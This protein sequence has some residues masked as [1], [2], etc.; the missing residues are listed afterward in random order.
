[1]KL[2]SS[3]R[4]CCIV[5]MVWTKVYNCLFSC[6]WTLCHA[7]H[8]LLVSYRRNEASSLTPTD[9][10]AV[11]LLSVSHPVSLNICT[12]SGPNLHMLT[13]LV[14]D[15][16]WYMRQRISFNRQCTVFSIYKTT[17]NYFSSYSQF[18]NQTPS[19][20]TASVIVP[21]ALGCRL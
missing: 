9:L 6:I 5:G 10:H 21:N 8:S 15:S 18:L 4:W 7:H 16:Y 20:T 1:M 14:L 19:N 17:Q 12:D 2:F 11:T 3:R 13:L